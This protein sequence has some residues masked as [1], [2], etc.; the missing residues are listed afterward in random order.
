M[1]EVW[2]DIFY[3]D[4]RTSE[5]IDFRN[6]YQISNLGN[7]RSLID[8]HGKRQNKLLKQ[9]E[10][11]GY[12][13]VNLSK[14]GKHKDF[15]IHRLVAHMFIENNEHKK[16]VNHKDENKHNNNVANLEWCTAKENCNYGTR[17]ERGG[18][19]RKGNKNP[20]SQM[21]IGINIKTGQIIK[22]DYIDLCKFDD[23]LPS[24]VSACCRKERKSHKGYKWYY[25]KDYLN[26]AIPSEAS[27]E[28][29]RTCN[30]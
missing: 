21:V 12:L 30:D 22:Y 25:L 14:N 29:T 26:M 17:N 24:K 6:Q 7:V 28:T 27:S 19:N 11:F 15:K 9:R 10:K 3:V 13:V 5:I 2:K 8:N 18:K 4:I 20:R 1:E 23:F 16:E